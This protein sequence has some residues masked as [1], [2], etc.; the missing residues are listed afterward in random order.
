[1][2]L[3]LFVAA[4]A[5]AAISAA[6]LWSPVA[7]PVASRAGTSTP[8]VAARA[9]IP[10]TDVDGPQPKGAG[11][12]GSLHVETRQGRPVIVREDGSI[13]RWIGASDFALFARFARGEDIRPILD[14]RIDLGFTILR[15]F[16]MFDR[17]GIGAA[18]GTG[19]LNPAAVADYYTKLRAFID[20]AA[21]RGIRLEL[22]VLADADGR[23]D[24]TG[25]LMSASAAQQTHLTRVLD[26]VQ[27]TWNVTVEWSNEAFKNAQGVTGLTGECRAPRVLCA[28]GSTLPDGPVPAGWP[29]LDYV[30]VHDHER[31]TEWPR[32]ARRYAELVDRLGKPVV[33]DEPMGFAESA[34]ADARATEPSDAAYFAAAVAMSASG[35]TFHSD[36]GVASRQFSPVQLE[37]AK[38]WAWAARWVPPEAQTAPSQEGGTCGTA[39]GGD[40]P[41]QHCGL[42]TNASSR[43][44]SSLCRLVS[45]TE[46]C[47]R[48]RPV[49]P[50]VARPGWRITSEPRPGFVTLERAE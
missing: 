4:G 25:G 13:F 1:M 27:G 5:V 23:P 2:R 41:I 15:V 8:Q 32:T 49:G 29:S 20:L 33:A 12:T 34:R 19:E 46:Y 21:A 16:T 48:V 7:P 37:A 11:E 14:Q 47:V 43:A 6:A 30:T 22:V 24:G 50:T 28:Y 31:S 26:V 35:A 45:P 18:A 44:L 39:G 40:M 3:S 42:D 17:F 10:T 38:A 36:D 9:S